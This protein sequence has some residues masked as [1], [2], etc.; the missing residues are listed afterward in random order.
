MVTL[1]ANEIEKTQ[2]C[3]IDIMKGYGDGS[4]EKDTQI[5]NKKLHDTI[6]PTR[7]E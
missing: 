5:R 3:H 7:S 6:H 4:K 1:H 2:C